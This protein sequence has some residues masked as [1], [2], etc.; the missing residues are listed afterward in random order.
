MGKKGKLF[1]GV[2]NKPKEVDILRFKVNGE[3][4]Q[5]KKV[6]VGV[7]NI[8]K[9]CYSGVAKVTY[10]SKQ[11]LSFSTKEILISQAYGD[12]P[13]MTAN[14]NYTDF[15]FNPNTTAKHDSSKKYVDYPWCAYADSYDTV[16]ANYGYAQDLLTK[17]WTEVGKDFGHKNGT[18]TGK[19]ICTTREDHTIQHVRVRSSAATLKALDTGDASS[20]RNTYFVE[21]FNSKGQS[22]F[23]RTPDNTGTGTYSL[24][25]GMKIN[26]YARHEDGWAGVGDDGSACK[27]TIDGKK[28]HGRGTFTYD[29]PDNLK[30]ISVR[31]D[32]DDHWDG[33]QSWV[34]VVTTTTL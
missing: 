17:Y 1:K 26:F 21:V 11:T 29:V 9:L 32:G 5:V 13:T 27:I 22:V 2:N 3:Y 12:L 6:Y 34:V 25:P 19:E 28:V 31:V 15:W 8:A 7:N 10:S 20:L 14:S 33:G 24:Y 30:T 16:Y 4:K 18:M 23:S